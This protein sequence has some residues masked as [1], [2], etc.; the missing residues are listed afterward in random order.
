MVR[1]TEELE[2]FIGW[3]SEDS[4]LEVVELLER[5]KHPKYKVVCNVCSKDP[6]L[7][8][9]G[10][11]ISTKSDLKRGVK[12]CG[13]SKAP[14][15]KGWQYLILA[16]RAV[17][18]KNI[19]IHG[20][21]EDFKGVN[22]RIACE[23]TLDQKLWQPTLAQIIHKEHGCPECVKSTLREM[24]KTPEL[25]VIERC[26]TICNEMNYSFI[27]FPDGYKNAKSKL[28]YKCSVHGLQTIDY[29]HF[30]RGSRC[31]LCWREK[32]NELGFGNGWYPERAEEQDFLYVLNFDEQYIK[33]GRS[34][35]LERRMGP[36]ELQ[37]ESGI[38]NIKILSVYTAKHGVTYPT[39][40][41]IHAELRERGF[42]HIESIWST[43][44]FQNDSLYVV[45]KLLDMS[46]LEKCCHNE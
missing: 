35:D 5:G 27:G 1:K 23:C 30:C 15:W 37:K 10:Y 29:D 26:K 28:E 31:G 18:N 22:T 41:E 14:R 12:P 6:E 9:L 44:T 43:E 2:D 19:V 17:E 36:R 46:G 25:V 21:T 45:N 39:E 33:V 40:Q 16:N 8:P 7:F 42:E 20:F 34:F 4:G 3:K 11:F 32:Q 38:S 24:K 13:C